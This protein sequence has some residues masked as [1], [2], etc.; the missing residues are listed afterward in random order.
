MSNFDEDLR[1]ILE[2]D[3]LGLLDVKPKK[4]RSLTA[5]DR[6]VASFHEIS[7]FVAEHGHEPT[8]SRDIRERRLYSRLA[9]LRASPEK[10]AQLVEYDV[11]GLLADV[12]VPEPPSIDNIDD[13]LQHDALGLLD[14][15]TDEDPSE[16]FRLTNIPEQRAA[17]DHVAQRKP[18]DEFEQFEPLFKQWQ[19]DLKSG[20]RVMVPFGREGQISA[21]STFVLRGM[22][23]YVANV[24]PWE[25]TSYGK[26][27]ARLYCVFENGTESNMLLRS[28]AAAL[29]K[30]AGSR[31]V[32]EA[33]QAH[34]FEGLTV[35][36]D[37]EATGHIYVLRSESTDPRIQAIEHLY[38]IGFS[39]HAVDLRTKN[40]AKEP[41]YLMADVSPVMTF[42]TF[43][44]NPQKL[45]YLVH[46]FFAQARLDLDVYDEHGQKH[47]PR[48]WFLVPIQ[49]IEAAVKLL[50]SGEILSYRYDAKARTIV[51]RETA[52]SDDGAA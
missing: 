5:D 14:E 31:Q 21:G 39:S 1:R 4:P 48:E 50:I 12:K 27:N 22:L 19:A 15:E 35:G 40:A 11:H 29:W 47:T 42:Q 34:L 8:Q 46:K 23:V 28:L 18:C 44:L 32:V 41:T 20:V 30:D 7:A 17:P 9:G 26:G 49:L 52:V 43:N 13:L 51:P 10:A 2:E 25:K 16:I 38:K 45:E 3:P 36:A 6:L 37:D 33:T 24:G